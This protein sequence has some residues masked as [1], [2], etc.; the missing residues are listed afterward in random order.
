MSQ[1]GGPPGGPPRGTLADLQAALRLKVEEL[2][3]ADALIQQLELEL[4]S[5]DQLV[6]QLQLQLDWKWNHDQNQNH[7]QRDGPLGG[8]EPQRTKRQAISA[9]PSVLDPTQLTHVSLTSYCKSQE[10]RELIQRA[11][12]DNDFMKHLEHGQILTIMDCMCP[13]S[14]SRGCCVI[15]E[16]DDGSTVYVLEEG[17]VEVTKQGKKLCSIGPGKVFGELAILYNCTRTATVT[18]LTDIKLWAIDRPGFQTIM[19]RTGLIKHSQYTDFLRSVPSFQALPEDVLS[20]LAD[21]L[22]ET[23]YCDGDYI[24]RQGASGDTFFIISDG[25][26]RHWTQVQTGLVPSGPVWSGLKGDW[27]GEQALKG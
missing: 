2:Q 21:I 8:D 22:E 27:F 13:T 1:P 7:N 4:D 6:R 26:V 16:G 12:L 18:A 10:S 24:I 9:E 14:L 17:M 15:Q 20:K 19:M 5:R 23:H 25:Q 3:Q 11:L